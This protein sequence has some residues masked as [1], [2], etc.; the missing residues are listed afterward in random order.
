MHQLAELTF[1]NQ[2]IFRF[3]PECI[4]GQ[5]GLHYLIK[6]KGDHFQSEIS[7]LNPS[8]AIMEDPTCPQAKTNCSTIRNT[9][10]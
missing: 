9:F 7:G 6:W 3:W 8:T 5:E 10:C 4:D 2:S 1:P